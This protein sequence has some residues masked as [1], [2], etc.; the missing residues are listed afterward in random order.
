MEMFCS[1]MSHELERY[2]FGF[3]QV[4]GTTLGPYPGRIFI[5]KL[6]PR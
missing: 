5:E 1:R 4:R 2:F 6:L 3:G